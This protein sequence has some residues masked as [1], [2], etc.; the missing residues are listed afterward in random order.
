MDATNV[1]QGLYL[2]LISGTSMDGV[3]AA[4]IKISDSEISLEEFIEVPYPIQLKADLEGL[5]RREEISLDGFGRLHVRVAHAFADT[6][7]E[8]LREA[9]I[10]PSEIIALGSHGQTVLHKPGSIPP[11]TLQLGDPSVIAH[12][13]GILTVADFRAK[14]MAAGGQGAPLVPA[15]HQVAF[16]RYALNHVVVN[17]GGIANISAFPE[18][19]AVSGFDTGPGNTLM[20][21]WVQQSLGLPFDR[22]GAWARSGKANEVLLSTMLADSYFALQGPRSSGRDYFSPAW[23]VGMVESAGVRS[24]PAEDIQATLLQLTARTITNAVF[25]T[26]PNCS[27]VAICGGGARNSNLMEAIAQL[28]TPAR[29]TTTDEMGLPGE[30][31]EACAFAWLAARRL[32][33][34]PGNLPSVTGARSPQVLGG[35]YHPG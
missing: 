23:L 30:A 4:I 35:V 27:Q 26:L 2:G 12:A 13:T 7:H 31:V 25:A 24:L 17:I 28:A 19:G 20:D 6:A 29:V 10:S 16:G 8:L 14:D 33:G 18:V 15:F 1:T 32:A 34:L 3:N 9:S 11:H 5:V 21:L 22:D